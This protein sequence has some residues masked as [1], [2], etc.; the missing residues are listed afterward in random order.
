MPCV[1]RLA[2]TVYAPFRGYVRQFGDFEDATLTSAL[3]AIPM[4]CS[5]CT[6]S[7]RVF[8]R[9]FAIVAFSIL[10][11]LNCLVLVNIFLSQPK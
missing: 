1:R 11:K 9:Y 3:D 5:C 6:V 4:V 2:T 10:Q 8:C 7:L